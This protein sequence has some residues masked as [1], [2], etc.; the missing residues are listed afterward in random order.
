MAQFV[1]FDPNVEVCGSAVLAIIEGM[2]LFT[3]RAKEVL[4][5][6]GIDSPKPEGWYPQQAWLD[7]FKTISETLGARTLFEIGR[8][9]P[10]TAIWP[11]DVESIADGLASIDRAYQLNH[12][13][14]NI[15]SYQ[16]YP[17]GGHS[18]RIIC[19][20]PYPCDFDQGIIKAIA[21]RFKPPGTFMVQIDHDRTLPCRGEG[22]D[23]CS[24][25]VRW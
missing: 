11:P 3:S 20:N 4:A 2:G 13:G 1:A 17:L 23:F 12:R 9:I 19:H 7:A 22:A 16:Y 24:Y 15:G 14:G 21:D 8:K 5:A 25:I 18:A 10:E 6:H